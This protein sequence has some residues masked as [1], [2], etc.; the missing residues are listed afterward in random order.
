MLSLSECIPWMTV[1]LA[2]SVTIV[3]LNLCAITVFI[4]N[5]NLR[6]RSMYLVINLA[7]IDMFIGGIAVYHLFYLPGVDCK[8]WKRQSEVG[9]NNY[10]YVMSLLF[11][12]ASLTNIVIIALERVHAS[13]FPFRHRVLKKCVYRLIIAIVWVTSGLGTMACILLLQSYNLYGIYLQYTF[14]SICLLI[15]CFSFILRSFHFIL[16]KLSCKSYII[17]HSLA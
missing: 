9:T 16:W 5:R 14:I 17:H 11:C 15:I 12:A 7:V 13:F 10:I 6:K 2:E 4:R 8:L 3:T 1:S